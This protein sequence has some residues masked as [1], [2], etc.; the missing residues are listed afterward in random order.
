MGYWH[1]HPM[2][3]DT[4]L[5]VEGGIDE[6]YIY[7]AAHAAG[8]DHEDLFD[9]TNLYARFLEKVL[10]AVLDDPGVFNGYEAFRFVLPYMV[11]TYGV[12]VTD[13]LHNIRLKS[14][15]GDGGAGERGFGDPVGDF[16]NP[17]DYAKELH[18]NWDAL[19][20]GEIGYDNLHK[21]RGMF[22]MLTDAAH[23]DG[24]SPINL[25]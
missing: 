14:M 7:P 24:N 23:K 20:R 12:K 10:P 1:E 15:I 13:E 18:D 8:V 16:K 22:E 19:M 9:K 2:A 3:G 6:A 5:D 17:A 21:E 4:P 11:A 25:G